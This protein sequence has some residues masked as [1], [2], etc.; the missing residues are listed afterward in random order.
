MPELPGSICRKE[1][2]GGEPRLT[3]QPQSLLY[4]PEVLTSV[5]Q[6]PQTEPGHIQE[7][8]EELWLVGYG[9][10]SPSSRLLESLAVSTLLG[11]T[12]HLGA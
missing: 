7:S 1:K 8:D 6:F 12:R 11:G 3:P 5:P 10:M 4:N 2:G 9:E